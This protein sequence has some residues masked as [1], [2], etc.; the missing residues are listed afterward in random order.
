MKLHIIIMFIMCIFLSGN[1]LSRSFLYNTAENIIDDDDWS[2]FF[3][4]QVKVLDSTGCHNFKDTDQTLSLGDCGYSCPQNV[5]AHKQACSTLTAKML[6][7]DE[8]YRPLLI[9]YMFFSGMNVSL[10]NSKAKEFDA[11]RNVLKKKKSDSSITKS[12]LK[13]YKGKCEKK[14]KAMQQELNK[15]S[16][17][18]MQDI[19]KSGP[20]VFTP[21]DKGS[22]SCI[23][24]YTVTACN[25][26]SLD[27]ADIAGFF[28]NIIACYKI[29]LGPPPPFCDNCAEQGV[30]TKIVPIKNASM[31]NPMI[32]VMVGLDTKRLCYDGSQKDMSENCGISGTNKIL[33]YKEEILKPGQTTEI[34]YGQIKYKFSASLN[35]GKICA[36]YTDAYEKSLNKNQCYD[37]GEMQEPIIKSGDD[38]KVTVVVPGYNKDKPFDIYYG[39]ENKATGLF[40]VKPER[41]KDGVIV[42]DEDGK[43]VKDPHGDL[44][45]QRKVP[46]N[47][48]SLRGQ[49]GKGGKVIRFRQIHKAFVPVKYSAKTEGWVADSIGRHNINIEDTDQNILDTMKN[50]YDGTISLRLDMDEEKHFKYMSIL[51]TVG[52]KDTTYV[53]YDGTKEGKPILM[54]PT[55][56]HNM[57]PSSDFNKKLCHKTPRKPCAGAPQMKDAQGIDVQAFTKDDFICIPQHCKSV[58]IEAWDQVGMRLKNVEDHLEIM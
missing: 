28:N 46:A 36:K 42:R 49:G 31:I 11:A 14:E 17:K 33:T 22:L 32:K 52:N 5:Y 43:V 38:K 56:I 21:D 18:L 40:L 4:P 35:K 58:V 45:L 41:D 57:R 16:Q 27:D 23:C 51:A 53:S 2:N 54:D 30:T 39:Q 55:E 24:A 1:A 34:S 13:K 20:L 8:K 3:Y 48:Y 15:A 6:S 12:E 37:L 9:N 47:D 29:P 26:S 7:S 10:Y 44:C 19:E 25:N 50:N